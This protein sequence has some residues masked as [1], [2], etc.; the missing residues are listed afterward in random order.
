MGNVPTAFLQESCIPLNDCKVA[1]ILSASASIFS[2]FLRKIRKFS[3]VLWW[4]NFVWS[5]FLRGE[6][7]IT[8]LLYAQEIKCMIKNIYNTDVEKNDMLNR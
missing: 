7:G 1:P 2:I 6:G 3:P 8:M 5:Y 4:I